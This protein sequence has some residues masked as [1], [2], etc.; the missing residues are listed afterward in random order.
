MATD[1]E[2]AAAEYHAAQRDVEDA[3]ARV[4][5]AQ[6]RF[7]TARSTLQASIVAE[8]RRGTRVRDLVAVSGFTREWIRQL[9]RGAGVDPE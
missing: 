7:T 1:L 6:Q 8:A 3:K 5:L 4:R 2:A 9:L